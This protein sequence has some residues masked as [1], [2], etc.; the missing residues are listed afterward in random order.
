MLTDTL[1][2][3][4]YHYYRNKSLSAPVV[5]SLLRDRRKALDPTIILFY[6]I[7]L[8]YILL[9]SAPVINVAL[10]KEGQEV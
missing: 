4:H 7:V 9:I 10:W 3:H 5:Q 1:T 2:Q 6:F 8:R